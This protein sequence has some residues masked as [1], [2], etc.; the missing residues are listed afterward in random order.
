M[1][2]FHKKKNIST[3]EMSDEEPVKQSKKRSRTPGIVYINNPPVY[4]KPVK[5]KHLLSQ[6]G[7]VTNIYL[8]PEDES[9]RKKRKKAGGSSKVRYTEG[10]IEFKDKNDA[11]MAAMVLNGQPVGGNRRSFHS[12]D[13][14]TVKYLSGFQWTHLTEKTAYERRTK[15][16]RLRTELAHAKRENDHYLESL[17][18]QKRSDKNENKSIERRPFK[19]V[20]SSTEIKSIKKA[21][22]SSSDK[23]LDSVF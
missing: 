8:S 5:V 16:V 15:N 1:I 4:M 22:V 13:L 18:K 14:W 21:K 9:M 17:S 19:Q 23:W 6:Y 12:E 7:S 3:S 10:W 20:K 11:K 2:S